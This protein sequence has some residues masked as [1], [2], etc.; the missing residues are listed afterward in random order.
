VLTSPF[1]DTSPAEAPAV[2][3]EAPTAQEQQPAEAEKTAPRAARLGLLEILE[4]QLPGVGSA[5]LPSIATVRAYHR[6]HQYVRSEAVWRIWLAVIF[7]WF[8]VAWSVV[9]TL[10]AW[11]GA[12]DYRRR[13][14][15]LWQVGLPGLV[16]AQLPPLKDLSGARLVWVAA[17][18]AVA[19]AGLK[20]WRPVMTLTYLLAVP[21]S[22]MF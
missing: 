7:G 21:L 16:R 11:A 22:C 13:L 9:F 15:T 1:A 5:R 8:A 10:I 20:F 14:R 17:W 12:G 19:W 3:E 2:V 6:A 18:S 4:A